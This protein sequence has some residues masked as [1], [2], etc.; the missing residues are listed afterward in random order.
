[1]TGAKNGPLGVINRL[2]I[3][4][5]EPGITQVIESAACEL[6]LESFVLH[7]PDQFEKALEAIKPTIIFLD[8]VMPD[9]DGMKLIAH[10]AAWNYPGR[11]LIVSPH[12]LHL[13]MGSTIA[14]THGLRL[15]D[16]LTKPLGK[17]QTL[18]LLRVGREALRSTRH[19]ST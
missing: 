13:K 10:L 15:A 6:G 4:D 3:I 7:G 18:D 5:D 1:V 11:V 14:E 16:L 8:I 12:P 19:G 17:R 2:L 9:R